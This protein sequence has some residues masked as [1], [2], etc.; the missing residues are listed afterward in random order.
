MGSEAFAPI[1]KLGPALFEYHE[2]TQQDPNRGLDMYLDQAEADSSLLRE[3]FAGSGT[4]DPLDVL[5]EVA[6]GLLGEDVTVAMEGSRNYFSGVVRDINSGAL[7]HY[8]DASVDTPGLA[9]GRTDSQLSFLLYLTDFVGGGLT[10]YDKKPT[11]QDNAEY[12]LGYGYSAE[13][14]QGAAFQG[15]LPKKGSVVVFNPR[16]IHSVAPIMGSQRRL[17]V[18]AFIGRDPAS[19]K[20]ISWS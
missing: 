18:S 6:G 4:P 7:P 5:H 10:S 16:F 8:D 12:Q 19:G 13:A 17:T 3:L 15:V 20:L 14:V 1:P 11:A 9:I 2:D